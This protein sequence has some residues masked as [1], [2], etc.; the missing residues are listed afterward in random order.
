MNV[1]LNYYNNSQFAEKQQY[2]LWRYANNDHQALRQV[3]AGKIFT[4]STSSIFDPVVGVQFTNT[5]TSYRRSFGSYQLSD[6]T[7]PGWLAELYV[8]NVLVNY[9]RADVSGFY[10][11]EVPLVYGNS[12][13]KLRFYGPWGEE[14][15]TEQNIIIPFNFL[16]ARQFEYTISAGVVEDSSN[17]RFS[18]ASFNYGAG[19]HVTF[20]G[21]MEYLSSVTTGKEMPFVNTSISLGTKLLLSGEYMYGVRS[22]GILT[23]RFLSNAQLEINYTRYVK[24]Q[25]AIKYPYREERKLALSMPVRSKTFSAYMRLTLYQIILPS[26]KYTT[27]EWLASGVF[28]HVNTNL[29]TYA[30]ISSQGAPFIYPRLRSR[31]FFKFWNHLKT[32][33]AKGCKGN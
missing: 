33:R 29:T 9:V 31:A 10:T 22:R 27:A 25:T 13:V 3:M 6:H 32:N 17:S 14:H 24:G 28:F 15:S 16:P 18:R 26:S 19:R 7:E 2:Y 20:G 1:S 5:P 12:M 11:F 8:N 4:H 21:G 30:I 23:Y